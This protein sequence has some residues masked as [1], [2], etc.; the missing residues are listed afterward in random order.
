MKEYAAKWGLGVQISYPLGLNFDSEKKK[1]GFS[2]FRKSIAHFWRK[3][4]FDVVGLSGCYLTE[5]LT[6]TSEIQ[7][8]Q[9]VFSPYNL[10]MDSIFV[11]LHYNFNLQNNFLLTLSELKVKL[12]FMEIV[13]FCFCFGHLF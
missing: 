6:S 5:S 13:F 3:Q 10:I 11:W 9:H 8:L 2:I 12:K 7:N 4:Y 1:W